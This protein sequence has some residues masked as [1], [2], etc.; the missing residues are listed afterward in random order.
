MKRPVAHAVGAS[1]IALEDEERGRMSL[2]CGG[3]PELLFTEN[4]TNAQRLYG[5]PNRT[6]FVKDS[7]ESYLVRGDERAV[8]PERRGTKAA[9]CYS[10]RVAAGETADVYLRLTDKNLPGTEALKDARAVLDVRKREADEFYARIVP[11]HLSDDAKLV[12]RQALAGMLWS[13]QYYHY[14]LAEWL[15][16]DRS[17]PEP[18]RERR[19]GRNRDWSHLYN[20]DVVSMPDKWEYPWYAAWDLAFHCVP[21]ALVDSEFAKEQ[22]VLLLREW[23]MHPNGQIPAYE[24]ALGDVN[25]PV[26]A[27]AAWRVYKIE[28]KRRGRG[29]RVFLERIFHKLMLNFTW[30]VNRKDAEGNNVFE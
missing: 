8:N 16:G 10:L 19:S 14:V 26:H 9:A 24:W 22:L 1:T 23:Y 25:P 5:V 2:Y 20:A 28:K 12:M 13:K 17:Q 15:D 7:F 3:E 6:P 21:L 18:P 11:S 27:W 4:D 30:W 29:D